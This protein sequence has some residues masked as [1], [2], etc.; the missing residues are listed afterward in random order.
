MDIEALKNSMPDLH[1]AAVTDKELFEKTID[2]T[3][4]LSEY[5]T[6]KTI[7]DFLQ[8][9][10]KAVNVYSETLRL[11][12]RVVQDAMETYLSN[13]SLSSSMLKAA[14]KTPLDFHFSLSEDKETL[15]KIK[16]TKAFELGTFIHQCILEP[17]KFSRAIVE[18][19]HGLN[20][21]D[22]C[23]KMIEFY[24][25]ILSEKNIEP[26]KM[27]IDTIGK[28]RE[29][30][31]AIKSLADVEPVTEENYL[32]IQILK[33]RIDAYAGGVIKQLL[34]HSKREISVYTTDEETGLNLKV[35]PDALQ[36]KEN[37]GVDAIISIKSTSA[38]S[39]KSFFSQAA[40]LHY[41]LTEG[42]YQE[43]VSKA[44]G[45]DFNTTIMIMLQT[46]EPY[47]IAVL[48][49]K[50]EDIEMGKY[51]FRNALH[52]AKIILDKG[53]VQ[54]YDVFA[55]EGDFGLINMELPRWNQQEYLPK[56]ID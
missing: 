44:T 24:L 9:T 31:R 37:I 3:R 21:T 47:H 40:E 7:T 25:N 28:K 35:R 11:N 14:F 39:L 48:V 52:D 49:W 2:F 51:K 5:P 6:I 34:L 32:K 46:V 15:Q 43:V 36:F 27:P 10:K 30:I 54:G 20:T 53:S 41:D 13:D 45:R 55:E 4:P 33:K 17:T 29:F 23:D 16:G 18:P 22:G 12:G 56:N 19:A 50:P 26:P 1:S 42:M 8:S 38:K